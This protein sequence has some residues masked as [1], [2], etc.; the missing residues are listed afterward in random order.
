MVDYPQV[1]TVICSHENLLRAKALS[2][3]FLDTPP[4]GYAQSC[5][6]G[7]LAQS[8]QSEKKMAADVVALLSG[9]R[10]VMH[11]GIDGKRNLLVE[12]MLRYFG[13]TCPALAARCEIAIV[14][15]P[16]L[17]RREVAGR[18]QTLITIANETNREIAAARVAAT[19]DH[20]SSELL[21]GHAL[22]A[23]EHLSEIAQAIKLRMDELLKAQ[24]LRQRSTS[25]S[26][27]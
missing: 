5:P 10:P 3:A 16:P 6:Q 27:L 15:L 1:A 23:I 8:G 19:G 12:E 22:A 11:D 13:E 17:A 25:R 20:A 9:G 21:F 2:Q 18:L 4:T 24:P 14:G 26:P 7:L